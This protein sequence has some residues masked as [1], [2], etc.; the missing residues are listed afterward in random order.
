MQTLHQVR[1]QINTGTY[2][3]FAREVNLEDYV[4]ILRFDIIYT[5]DQ[6]LVHVKD[7]NF[8]VVRIPRLRQMDQLVLYI[9]LINNC[10]VIF[11]EIESCKSMLKM[12]SMQVNF[13]GSSALVNTFSRCI[14]TLSYLS[15][16]L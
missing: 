15:Y 2:S 5:M 16:K 9:A 11:N 10:Q 13:F 1:S 14:V 12:L 6:G 4:W 3:L 8:A 7:E